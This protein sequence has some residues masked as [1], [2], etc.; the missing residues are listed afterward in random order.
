MRATCPVQILLHLFQAITLEDENKF[1]I[2]SFPPLPPPA[3]LSLSLS[4]F[5]SLTI[6]YST[7]QPFL[8]H[9]GNVSFP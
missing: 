1:Y 2:S 6:K 4:L 7:Q 8:K 9:R 5:P 3:L